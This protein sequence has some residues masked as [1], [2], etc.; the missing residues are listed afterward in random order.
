MA[1]DLRSRLAAHL[2]LQ[3]LNDPQLDAILHVVA[4]A[5]PDPAARL[6]EVGDVWRSRTQD[7]HTVEVVNFDPDTK[8]CH[9]LV[10]YRVL[11]INGEPAPPRNVGA[12][13]QGLDEFL[14]ERV[15]DHACSDAEES[16]G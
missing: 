14:T 10:S 7:G 12:W 13:H 8:A 15:F 4:G 11:T 16:D 2:L 3:E 1:D 6:P 5:A 9:S